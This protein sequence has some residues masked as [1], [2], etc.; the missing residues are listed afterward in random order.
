MEAT[1]LI[2]MP[3][4]MKSDDLKKAEEHICILH[5]LCKINLFQNKIV[6]SFWAFLR[7]D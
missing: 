6:I 7:K 3:C 1:F 5:D 2:T 4:G